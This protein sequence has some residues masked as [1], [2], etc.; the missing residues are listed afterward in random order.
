M[1]LKEYLDSKPRGS[2][3]DFAL[4]LGITRTWL[5]LILNGS[6]QP[7]IHLCIQIE[8]LTKG[9]VKRKELRPDFFIGV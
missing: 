2:K 7:S 1:Q 8:K 3:A 4:Q 5:A 6:A 9:R